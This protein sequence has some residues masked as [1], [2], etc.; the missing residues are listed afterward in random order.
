MSYLAAGQD[1]DASERFKKAIELAP[2]DA[3]LKAKIDAAIKE[4]IRQSKG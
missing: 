2:K 3:E 4:S 1:A